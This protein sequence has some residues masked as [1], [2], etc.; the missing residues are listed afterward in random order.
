MKER[1]KKRYEEGLTVISKINPHSNK[2]EGVLYYGK[3]PEDL[4][5]TIRALGEGQYRVS[6][7]EMADESFRLSEITY[8]C[9]T[10]GGNLN[11]QK[12]TSRTTRMAVNEEVKKRLATIIRGGET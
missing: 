1:C 5:K 12:S 11:L 3:R 8:Q 10:E 2:P 4:E 9:K 7:T 6:T